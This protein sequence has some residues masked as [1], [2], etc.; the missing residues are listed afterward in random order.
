MRPFFLFVTFF[1]VALN[2][3]LLAMQLGLLRRRRPWPRWIAAGLCCWTGFVLIV[4][5]FQAFA[6]ATWHPFLRRWFYFPIAVEMVWNLLFVEVLVLATILVSLALR[7]WRPV[8]PAAYAP[9]PKAGELSRRKFVY[10]LAFGAAPATALGMGV[11]GTLTRYDL[12]TREFLIPV[13]G[14][15]PELEGFTIAHVSDLHSGIF[16]GPRRLKM[17]SDMTNDLKADLVT[18]TGDIINDSM[19]DFEAALVSMQRIEARYGTFLCEG[20]HDL[21]PGPG[22]VAAACN[23]HNL[24]L[25]TDQTA[26][27][28]VEGRRLLIGGLPWMRAGTPEMVEA[29]YPERREG[30][31]RILLAH[32]PHLFDVAQSVDLVLAGHTHGGQVMVGPV[33]LGPLFFRYWS[34]LYARGKTT[35]I[36]SNGCGDWFPCRIGAP[37]EIGLL[38]LTRQA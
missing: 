14:L 21:I 37:A 38:R 30:D 23:G 29:L 5:F 26:T 7:W 27:V 17:I 15:P 3:S 20:N 33:G 24:P 35:M 9:E 36:V 2:F 6:P 28:T 31:V 8:R 16:C 32:H 25:L 11:H 22:L 19:R 12:R 1:F 4:F 34:G 13:A 18:I 10:L